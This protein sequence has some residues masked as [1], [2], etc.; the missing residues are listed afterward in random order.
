[1]LHI[2]LIRGITVFFI[3]ISFLF[4]LTH[5]GAEKEKDLEREI[6]SL[7]LFEEPLLPIGGHPTE[8]ESRALLDALSAYKTNPLDVSPFEPYLMRYPSSPWRG[9]LLTN[10]GLACY[11]M[12]SFSKAL[13]SWERAWA[14][15]KT[16]R[17]GA[18]K[19]Y[20]DRALGELLEMYAR[21]GRKEV[22][23][24]LFDE[25]QGRVVTGAATERV[26]AAKE[27]LW[28]MQTHPDSAFLCGP[29]ALNVAAKTLGKN[30]SKKILSFPST[31]K[32]TSLSQIQTLSVRSGLNFQMARRAS[33]SEIIVPSVVHWK[34]GHFAAI[35]EKRDGLYLVRDT[36]FGDQ[37]WMTEK[38]ID[39]EA[40]GY[41]LIRKGRLP[42]GWKA[43][44]H[45][46]GNSIWGKGATKS[47]DPSQTMDS[48]ITTNDCG[49]SAM[50]L[51]GQM[52]PMAQYDIQAMVVGL[53]IFDTPVGYTPP[54]GPKVFY[55]VA[56][57][58]RESSQPAVFTHSNFGQKW[59]GS[60]LGIVVDNPSLPLGE[61]RVSLQNGGYESYQY[62][63]SANGYIRNIRSRALLKKVSA[64][65]IVY[66]RHLP[67]GSVEVYNVS[68]GG[69]GT[70]RRVFLKQLVD[71]QGNALTLN[72]DSQGGI[73]LISIT[74]PIGQVTRIFYELPGDPLKVT[75]ITDPFGRSAIFTYESGQLKK[76]TDIIGLTS[77]FTY[78]GDFIET[79]KT[80][81]ETT[82]FRR[83]DPVDRNPYRWLEATDSQGRTERAEF[84]HEAPGISASDP[85]SAVPGSIGSN[86]LLQYRNT[87]Y[88]DKRAYELN[89]RGKNLNDPNTKA[90]QNAK[91]YHWLHTEE[92]DEQNTVT[93]GVLEA[94]KSPLERRVFYDYQNSNGTINSSTYLNALVV[95][96]APTRIG[97]RLDDGS[98]QVTQYRYNE[99]GHTTSA[100]D[101]AGRVTNFTYD[102]G[103]NIDL[104]E[105]NR[106]GSSGT[107]RL[108]T[109]SDYI[110]HRPRKIR[111]ASGK[112]TNVSYN[113]QGQVETI[114][115]A[116]NETTRF[117]YFPNRY[118]Q[119]V[120]GADGL[121]AVS[122]IYDGKNRVKERTE[123]DGFTLSYEYDD[124]DRPRKITYPDGTYE[125]FTY[126][127]LDL[128]TYRDRQGRITRRK[129]N[130]LRQLEEVID[131]KGQKTTFS[132]C[133][134]GSLEGFTDSRG[135][136]TTFVKDSQGRLIRK[137][138][139]NG[140]GTVYTY[141]NS[142]SRLKD[143][144]QPNG[145]TTNYEYFL[146]NNLRR[147][148][149]T[150][151]RGY[152]T[153][154]LRNYSITGRRVEQ[155][156]GIVIP[157][158]PDSRS[159]SAAVS[160]RRPRPA[161]EQ[162]AMLEARNMFPEVRFTY[163]TWVN[164]VTSMTDL[165][166]VTTYSYYPVDGVTPG[167]GRLKAIDSP[168]VN[169][170]IT[171]EYD[172]IGRLKKRSLN[173]VTVENDYDIL[174]RFWKSYNSHL[175]NFFYDYVGSTS[176]LEEVS[177][178]GSPLSQRFEYFQIPD[179]PRLKKIS[180]K[181]GSTTISESS[182]TYY[183][184][185]S[186]KTWGEGLGREWE[187]SYDF[188]DQLTSF[189]LKNSASVSWR[190][191]YD[192]S[193]NRISTIRDNSL[194]TAYTPNSLNQITSEREYSYPSG[195][196][197][198]GRTVNYDQNG[199]LTS[200]LPMS[201]GSNIVCEW[202][203]ANRLTAI[204]IG[205]RRTKL[206]Y[207]G[208]S[209]WTKIEEFEG[210]T[211]LD[212]KTFIWCGLSLCEQRNSRGT[213]RYFPQ[214]FIDY[215]GKPY[216][217]TKDHLG[218][219]REVL[220]SDGQVVAKYSYEPYGRKIYI[221]TATVESDFGFT[222]HFYHAESGLYLAPFRAYSPSL[223]RW[224]SRD[225]IGEMGGLNL[226]GY[227][228]NNPVRWID[229]LG[230][231]IWIE[232][233]SLNEP[234]GHLSINVGDPDGEYSSY[235]FGVNGD[236]YLGGEVYQDISLL[237]TFY[238]GYYLDT[239]LIEDDAAKRYLNGLLGT[240]APYRPWNTC[241]NFSFTYFDLF[242]QAG[243]G[244]PGTPP[245]RPGNPLNPASEPSTIGGTLATDSVN[246]V[247]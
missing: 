221:G 25:I 38:V 9:A 193:G 196:F 241:R 128:A 156:Q 35:A 124:L 229:Q 216:F 111:D 55:R 166:G 181:W 192:A 152:K 64:S 66:E 75:K 245:V 147:I 197:R 239:T 83:Q 225:P 57:N 202:D 109:L 114:R 27:G 159:D 132:W 31:R 237:G 190:Y 144:I 3:T 244:K 175:G 46:E 188:I 207:D 52:T 48:S 24:A 37:W 126:D 201:G 91:I 141:E 179:D 103:G 246:N 29:Y 157:A 158:H 15:L 213:R 135:E 235:S 142:T 195:V 41:F 10:I 7:R 98:V 82:R 210:N 163:D 113:S 238:P 203:F 184:Q 187:L 200:L 106:V 136:T 164:R 209:R 12:G 174:G 167:S 129:Y 49:G 137:V 101:P 177:R 33:S 95:G 155:N 154:I 204:Q 71:P 62:S 233:P 247:P 199:N 44:F 11:Q 183:P 145:L 220:S 6:S 43:V 198:S 139:P 102:A 50:S 119:R 172:E 148:F 34:V 100:T 185:G 16:E 133:G 228:L 59:T 60:F 219:I 208:L 149:Y 226:Y 170:T 117:E 115:N 173:G 97:R 236:P 96:H 89:V 19:A 8:E 56:Y 58:Q 53:T 123:A 92:R 1:M 39:E 80:P 73:R 222:G 105:V 68:D 67:D 51:S 127:R 81:Y 223:G 22:L 87:F 84:R 2:L 143:I 88:W 65:P 77:E 146:D 176:R 211:L 151:G 215:D 243:F 140:T 21:L 212:T 110:K 214:G 93:S 28:Q 116:K 162:D 14:A 5:N 232:G 42:D 99:L 61:V 4:S 189:K 186:V 230:Y 218:S 227:V 63:N 104:L 20:A 47:N 118:L 224:I 112:E 217:Y 138:F 130:A 161:P 86:S 234:A 131:A 231:D 125:E 45:E 165:T 194:L 171:Y 240:K 26:T 85:T 153:P 94:V 120:V 18:G 242:V 206:S 150:V 205:N 90:Y 121:T 74:D 69:A 182:Y 168:A 160:E 54:V 17:E 79:L 13:N 23:E 169:D 107:E 178:N 180:S 32:G 36:T 191:E 108:L 70:V 134:C 72:Y 76:I 122:F 40:S 30:Q 78:N